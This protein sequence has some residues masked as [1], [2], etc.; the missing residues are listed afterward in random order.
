MGV[1]T[2]QM[3]TAQQAEA[4]LQ[5]LMER[6]MAGE[7]VDPAELA[8]A[9]AALELAARRSEFEDKARARAKREAAE[10]AA[11]EG[12]EWFR[13]E[14]PPLAERV[15]EAMAAAVE[16]NRALVAA[17]ADYQNGA[18]RAVRLIGRLRNSAPDWPHGRRLLDDV[19]DEV[20]AAATNRPRPTSAATTP[21]VEQF[22]RA[23]GRPT[24]AMAAK[25][26]ERAAR[27]AG[28]ERNQEAARQRDRE[29]HARAI[30]AGSA[31]GSHYSDN[32]IK[33]AKAILGQASEAVGE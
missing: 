1:K 32:D 19:F 15:V 17:L 23:L 10:A 26:E 30:L 27:R 22:H 13:T 21:L 28:W 18:D 12:E 2:W 9:K 8:A 29:Q 3:P 16:A 14:A 24:A 6:V 7:V 33:R 5:R 4:D 11:A 20:K 31:R 25:D